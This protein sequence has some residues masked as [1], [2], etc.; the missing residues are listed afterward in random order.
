MQGITAVNCVHAFLSLARPFTVPHQ[1]HE[2]E[3]QRLQAGA[4]FL[5]HLL[6]PTET[7]TKH[8]ALQQLWPWR[9]LGACLLPFPLAEY[10]TLFHTAAV[11]STV[12]TNTATAIPNSAVATDTAIGTAK[13]DTEGLVTTHAALHSVAVA[14]DATV[15]VVDAVG[16]VE[17]HGNGVAEDD[18][19]E[20]SHTGDTA[21]TRGECGNEEGADTEDD[22]AEAANGLQVN[23][24]AP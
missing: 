9:L 13:D 16:G 8:T 11:N 24:C 7:H 10:S 15:A 18:G 23:S 17:Q 21:H 1:P 19:C 20:S 3:E 14:A 6:S 5:L 12:P 22:S 4:V 2:E